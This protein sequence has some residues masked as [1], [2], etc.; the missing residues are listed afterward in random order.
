[1]FFGTQ[2]DWDILYITISIA[3]ILSLIG[4]HYLLKKV[5]NHFK[6]Y[7]AMSVTLRVMEII[8]ILLICYTFW[9]PW[10]QFHIAQYDWM[11][12]MDKI[13]P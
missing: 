5:I 1:M 4:L 10:I 8:L 13:K 2:T 3:I 6:W 7:G 11:L 9:W 12:Q